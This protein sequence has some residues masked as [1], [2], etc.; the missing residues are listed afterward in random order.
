MTEAMTK[1]ATTLTELLDRQREQGAET[2]PDQL[3]QN[4]EVQQPGPDEHLLTVS[5]TLKEIGAI[6][7]CVQTSVHSG[8]IK[9]PS[10]LNT[11]NSVLRKFH[12]A[13]VIYVKEHP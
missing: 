8:W 12:D 2:I 3:P 7:A 1:A 10:D 13:K 4:A 9:A 6:S 11:V 5:L